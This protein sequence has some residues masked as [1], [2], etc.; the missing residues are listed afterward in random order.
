MVVNSLII[1]LVI[2]LLVLVFCIKL[3]AL[4]PVNRMHGLSANTNTY[5]RQLGLSDVSLVSVISTGEIVYLQP[6]MSLIS[7]QLQF[8]CFEVLIKYYIVLILII[9]LLSVLVAFLMPLFILPINLILEQFSVFL[10]VIR[11]N[12]KVRSCKDWIIILFQLADMLNSW[13]IFSLTITGHLLIL[14]LRM[15]FLK[16]SYSFLNWLNQSSVTVPINDSSI[17]VLH[18]YLILLINQ[19]L[20]FPVFINFP[21]LIMCHLVHLMMNPQ[22]CCILLLIMLQILIMFQLNTLICSF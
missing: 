2:F 16:N 4:T 11:F 20:M 12:K 21:F 9:V 8:F 18:V 15:W 13:S 3:L 22:V 5:L 14:S 10:Q 7:C 17:P 6:H 19:S 1:R